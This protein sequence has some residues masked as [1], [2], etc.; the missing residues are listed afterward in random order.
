MPHLSS[1]KWNRPMNNDP[2]NTC[3]GPMQMQAL[4]PP[5]GHLSSFS[6]QVHAINALLCL[7]SLFCFSVVGVWILPSSFFFFKN[8]LTAECVILAI[9]TNNRCNCNCNCNSIARCNRADGCW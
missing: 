5:K 4:A 7:C 2:T 9:S 3:G 6:Q 1:S 8:V